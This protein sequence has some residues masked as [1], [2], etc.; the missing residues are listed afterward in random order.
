M[1]KS[2]HLIIKIHLILPNNLKI[3]LILEEIKL[4]IGKI[5]MIA[6][7]ILLINQ[8]EAME[9]LKSIDLTPKLN[10]KNQI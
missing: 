2:S 1:M 9:T 5:K 6:I 10:S 3:I 8:K 7:M 4:L